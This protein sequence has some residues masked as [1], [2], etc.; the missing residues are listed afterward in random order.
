MSSVDLVPSATTSLAMLSRLISS[1][2]YYWNSLLVG[3]P[4]IWCVNFKMVLPAS[5][6]VFLGLTTDLQ[7]FMLHTGFL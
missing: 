5:S 4:K 6:A 2:F 7:S 1:C 3:G